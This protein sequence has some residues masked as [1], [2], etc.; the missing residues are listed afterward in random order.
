MTLRGGGN[1]TLRVALLLIGSVLV[2]FP[3]FLAVERWATS[4]AVERS[5]EAALGLAR[6]RA[7]Q[8]TSELQKFQ[9]LP[10]VLSEHPDVRL[11]LARHDPPTLSRLNAKLEKLAGQTGAA[12]IY[13]IDPAGNAIAASNWRQ[14][15]SFV[16][17]NYRFRPYFREAL[18]NGSAEMFALGIISMRPGLFIS[19]RVE[20]SAK[21]AGVVVV[22]VEFDRLE[23][24]WR[25]LPGITFATDRNG[26]V[27]IT[28]QPD[29]RFRAVG[30]IAPD[31][32]AAI[33][34]SLQF[35]NQPIR[36][37][38]LRPDGGIVDDG[39]QPYV[40]A[41]APIPLPQGRLHYLQPLT[42]AL[43]EIAANIRSAMLAVVAALVVVLALVVR[44]LE[45]R[46]REA[47]A[48]K[49]LER[50]VA[51]RTAELRE[52]NA[53]LT[54]AW[55]ERDQAD[56]RFRQAREELA[57]ANRLSTIGQIIAGVVHEV[58]QPVAAIRSYADNAIT[59][60]DRGERGAVRSNL[61]T[62]AKLASRIGAITGELRTFSRRRAMAPVA[63][64][65]GRAIDG[66]LLLIGDRLRAAGA[67]LERSGDEGAKVM[68][69][70]V[71]LEQILINLVQNALDAAEPGDAP[72]ILV[73]TSCTASAVELLVADDGPGID[74]DLADGLF[75]PFVTGRAEGV[76]L[77][78][79]IARDLARELGGELDLVPSPL[80]GAGF[81]L[82]LVPA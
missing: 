46:Q 4:R 18:A 67:E 76:G 41:E 74:N 34:S 44:A 24:S 35:G 81:R 13:L 45:T 42:P 57:Q 77:G 56:A 16:G 27:V 7:E 69:D 28:S 65:V 32:A 25:H 70:R 78:L 66:A 75:T 36:R 40:A 80:C 63:I 72:R 39:Q 6:N 15:T 21:S 30:P 31:V 82:T 1:R 37:L 64:P 2:V 62:M 26:V 55:D 53:R 23:S 8:V 47:E 33:R 14:P 79:A 68:G 60:L 11:A 58:N 12:V 17:T 10:I 49:A 71:R 38:P 50:E 61:A 73:A 22:K 54:S 19:R 3:L 29:W 51:L 48:R 9:L 52:T 20:G 5:R 43:E 59:L